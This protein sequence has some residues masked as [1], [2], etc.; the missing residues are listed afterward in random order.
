MRRPSTAVRLALIMCATG[1]K[2]PDVTEDFSHLML[3]EKVCS[4]EPSPIALSENQSAQ[5]S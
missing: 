3:D 2:P 4:C 5:A 1:F